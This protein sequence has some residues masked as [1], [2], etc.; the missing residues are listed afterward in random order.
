MQDQGQAGSGFQVKC[1]LSKKETYCYNIEYTKEEEAVSME[2]REKC[3]E[4]A[5]TDLWKIFEKKAGDEDR[6]SVV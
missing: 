5:G 1:N 4:I 3:P 2:F 6:K